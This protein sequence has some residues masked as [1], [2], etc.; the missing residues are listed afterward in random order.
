MRPR[1]YPV[2]KWQLLVSKLTTSVSEIIIWPQENPLQFKMVKTPR[3]ALRIAIMLVF[4]NNGNHALNISRI[5]SKVAQLNIQI[6]ESGREPLA[7]TSH[8]RVGG[9]RENTGKEGSPESKGKRRQ[10]SVSHTWVQNVCEEME[11]KGFLESIRIK[12]PRYKTKTPHYRLPVKDNAKMLNVATLLL[13]KC[14]LA[15]LESDYGHDIVNQHVVPIA[16]KAL[17]KSL[18]KDEMEDVKAACGGSPSALSRIL[19]PSLD[20][21]LNRS[22]SVLERGAPSVETLLEY[23]DA[24]FRLDIADA[25]WVAY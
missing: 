10:V 20:D 18:T 5:S 15:F 2:E 7:R 19:D 16:E 11:K 1:E 4:L 21:A 23:L 8:E 24:A 17:G 9:V 13:Q 6:L 25:K 22:A 12:P 3:V 14:P